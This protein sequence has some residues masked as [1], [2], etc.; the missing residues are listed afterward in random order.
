MDRSPTSSTGRPDPVHRDPDLP[1]A[2][3]SAAG[4]ETSRP[5][6]ATQTVEGDPEVIPTPWRSLNELQH[7]GGIAPG[8]HD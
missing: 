4:E 7:T 2:L 1:T 8:Q 5:W 6:E 3:A